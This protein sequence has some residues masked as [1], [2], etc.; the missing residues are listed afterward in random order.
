MSAINAMNSKE[1]LRLTASV[2][3]KA[4]QHRNELQGVWVDLQ[5]LLRLVR[6][7]ARGEYRKV[8]WR[9]VAVAVGALLYVLDPLDA[10]PD[11]IPG[12]GFLDDATMVAL[13][14]G[15]IRGDLRRFLSWESGEASEA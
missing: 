2:F 6:A 13:L 5:A 12:I 9:S 3:E 11:W 8:P 14:V 4:R 1:A 15:S 10:I 7:W